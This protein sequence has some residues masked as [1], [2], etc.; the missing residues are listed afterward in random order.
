MQWQLYSVANKHNGTTYYDIDNCSETKPKPDS[1]DFPI[2]PYKISLITFTDLETEGITS[3]GM[4]AFE[5]KFSLVFEFSISNVCRWLSRSFYCKGIHPFLQWG[6][7]RDG[8]L[9]AL[10]V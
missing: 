2:T 1:G 9:F 5:T 10:C 8:N 3:W 4:S 7:T 6:C